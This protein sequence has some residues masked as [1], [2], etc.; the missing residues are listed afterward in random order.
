MGYYLPMHDEN[1]I[2]KA[3]DLIGLSNLAN[4]CDVTYQSVRKWEKRGKLPRTE[5]T[6]ET[7][8][9]DVIE[10]LSKKQITKRQLLSLAQAA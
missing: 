4:E 2:T 1:L 10:R 5:W 9:S 8:Y 7:S 3:I 6:G